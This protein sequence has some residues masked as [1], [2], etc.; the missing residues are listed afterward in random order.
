MAFFSNPYLYY[1]LIGLQV[2]CVIH[3]IRKGTSMWWIWLIIFLPFFGSMIYLF[4][5]VFS[6]RDLRKVQS[7]VGAVINPGGRIKDLEE[8][9]RFADTFNNRV[10]LADAYL[11]TGDAD[12]A[13]E[14]YESVLTGL[15]V[16]NEYVII[17]LIAAY[18]EKGR[19]QSIL[20]I[21]PRIQKTPDFMRS[22]SRLLYALALDKSGKTDLAEKEFQGL[23]VRFSAYEARY[24]Y[25]LFLERIGKLNDAR[26]LFEEIV[27]EGSHLSAQEKRD[28]RQ[29][30]S[31]AQEALGKIA[32]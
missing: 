25:G 23:N 10:T 14:L 2:L 21:A 26:E 28:S 29:W 22:R 4:M 1:A 18:Y 31:K 8:K 7:S 6:K 13:I 30:I 17:N 9:L 16:D 3:V 15:F 32:V 27:R 5:E 20:Q 19:Y 24:E 11:A 12:R